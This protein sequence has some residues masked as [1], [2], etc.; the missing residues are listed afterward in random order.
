MLNIV[1]DKDIKS[2][3][4]RVRGAHD[5]HR[6]QII[7]NAMRVVMRFGFYSDEKIEV[8]YGKKNSARPPVGG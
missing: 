2:A 5:R 3:S 7:E 4:I 1:T 8:K 6:A